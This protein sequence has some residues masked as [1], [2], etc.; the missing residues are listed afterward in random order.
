MTPARGRSRTLA[1]LF[2]L[3]AAGRLAA[4]SADPAADTAIFVLRPQP[5]PVAAIAVPIDPALAPSPDGRYFAALQT[6]PAPVLWIIPT[7]GG[8]PFSYREM[9]AAYKPRWSPSGHRIGFIAGIGPPRIWTIDVD[10]TSGR[11]VDPPRLLY[12][13][14]ANAFAFAPDGERVAFVPQRTTAAGASEV[15]L[16]VWE[17][18]KV[19]FLLREDGMIYRLDWSP[20]GEYLYYGVAPDAAD[21]P[22]RVVRA[23]I[24]DAARTTVSETREFLGLAPDGR[25][26]LLRPDEPEA[27]GDHTLEIVTADGAPLLRV[28]V[29]RGPAPTWGSSSSSLV[30]ARANET[31][32]EIVAIAAP[33]LWSFFPW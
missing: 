28:A 29:P 27:N 30:Q 19:S 14:S 24:R 12:R 22:H 33:T 21:A 31:G 6:R 2:C 8:E 4:Q 10:P 5:Q 15:H 9:W 25:S 16:V 20:D 3:T 23:R 17:T 18:R 11:P 32:A 26:L 1:A 7:G 13:A